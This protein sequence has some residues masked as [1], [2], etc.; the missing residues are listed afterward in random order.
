MHRSTWK[1]GE[2]R[3]AKLFGAE[4]NSLSG[5]NSKLSSSDSTH[6]RLYLES[7]HS[8]RSALWTLYLR[9]RKLARKEGKIPVLIT[10]QTG[11]RGCLITL[12]QDHL[13]DM[14]REYANAQGIKIETAPKKTIT[15]PKRTL[16]SSNPPGAELP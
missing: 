6:P 8:K 14:L 9:T 1:K 16:K 4:R 13:W 3:A 12:H 7:K 10:R 11:C 15:I 5:R 2:S